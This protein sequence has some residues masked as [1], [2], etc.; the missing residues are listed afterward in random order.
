[1]TMMMLTKWQP[2]NRV[3]RTWDPFAEL[4]GFRRLFDQPFAS[5]FQDSPLSA[6]TTAGEW[7]PLMDVAETKEGFSV[8]VEIPGVKQEEIQIAVEDNTLTVKGERKHEAE[9]SEEGYRRIERSH[10]AFERAI[11]LPS[12][13]DADRIKATYTNG[14]LE[15]RLPKKEEAKPRT[16]KVETA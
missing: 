10:G 4:E 3:V 14:V 6:G 1:M 2:R 13:V 15:I 5:L 9:T 16:V 7:R 8:K 12:T 11:L